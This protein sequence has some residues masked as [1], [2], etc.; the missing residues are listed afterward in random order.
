MRATCEPNDLTSEVSVSAHKQMKAVV[1]DRYG[2]ADVLELRMIDHPE[3]A[4][5][6]VLIEVH[7][8]GVDRGVWH[9]MTGQPYLIRLAGFGF[10]RPKNPVLG[11]DVAGRVVAVGDDVTRFV[12]GDEVFGIAKGSY[13]QYAAADHNKLALKPTSTS[14]E[15]AAAAAVSGTTALEALIDVGHVEAGEKVLIVGASGGVGTFAIQLAK[16]LGAEVTA[17]GGPSMANVMRSIGADHVLD[18][19]QDDFVDGQSRYDLVLDIGG[20]NSVSRLR[21]VLA[22]RGTLVIVGGE[23]GNRLT[24][25]VGRQLRAMM[26][27]PFIRQR[28]TIFISSEHHTN[29][30]RLAD[31]LGSGA[32]VSSIGRR[33]ALEDVPE[34]IRLFET[35]DSRGKSVVV[36]QRDS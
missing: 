31:Y 11:L 4:V 13:A 22:A 10:F 36:V 1:R 27:S 16:A 20:R 2:A 9:L 32:V 8:A 14:F 5:D 6:E 25:G 29:I 3:I 21:S 33:F 35:A 28:L 30:E 19:T 17:V 24:G 12:P 7:A 23:G 26:L 18:Y 34:A 15:Q